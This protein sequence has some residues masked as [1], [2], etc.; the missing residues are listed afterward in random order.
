CRP[1]VQKAALISPRRTARMSVDMLIP[2]Q[3]AASL[4][5]RAGFIDISANVS[6]ESTDANLRSRALRDPHPIHPR[7][8]G[9]MRKNLRTRPPRRQGRGKRSQARQERKRDA[10]GGYAAGLSS[11]G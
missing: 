2:S 3:A 7:K 10:A 1:G 5:D 11:A 9:G 8:G 4:V 6:N